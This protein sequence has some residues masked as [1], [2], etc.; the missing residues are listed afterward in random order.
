MLGVKLFAALLSRPF[1]RTAC[2][3]DARPVTAHFGL[4]QL[5]FNSASRWICCDALF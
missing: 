5:P 1:H 2:G 4:H 3:E